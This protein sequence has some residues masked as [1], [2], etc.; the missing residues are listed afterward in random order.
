MGV[1]PDPW[2]RAK[3]GWAG[4]RDIC[5]GLPAGRHTES[6]VRPLGASLVPRRAG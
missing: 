1:N 5:S 3:A 2:P 6:N 4:D